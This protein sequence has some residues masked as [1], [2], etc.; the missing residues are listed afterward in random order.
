MTFAPGWELG[1]VNLCDARFG[2]YAWDTRDDWTD[3]PGW[4]LSR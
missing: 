3:K 2:I 4:V 1:H